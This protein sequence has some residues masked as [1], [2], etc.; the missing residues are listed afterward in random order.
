MV[1]KRIFKGLMG[2]TQSELAADTPAG[3][4]L[5]SAL[6][7]LSQKKRH[8]GTA[9]D[10]TEGIAELGAAFEEL[11]RILKE[12]FAGKLD[13]PMRAFACKVG[14]LEGSGAANRTKLRT[15]FLFLR[16]PGRPGYLMEEL[17]TD[18]LTVFRASESRSL[19]WNEGEAAVDR[20]PLFTRKAKI[21]GSFRKVQIDLWEMHLGKAPRNTVSTLRLAEIMLAKAVQEMNTD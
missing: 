21:E 20:T 13:N 9:V 16:V 10:V 4:E 8:F 18:E 17:E 11:I 15:P 14:Y 12:E 3:N 5:S 6:H 1:F 19:L 2:E 7:T